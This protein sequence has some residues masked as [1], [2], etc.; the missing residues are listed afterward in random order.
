MKFAQ[1]SKFAFNVKS[2]TL[3]P[4]KTSEPELT[5]IAGIKG[6]FKINEAASK[7]MGLK[8][9]DYLAF[10]SNE[11]QI[12]LIKEA[13][14]DTNHESHEDA[15]EFV[16]EVGGVENLSI[17]WGIAKGWPLLDA[18][19]NPLTTKK[20]LTK[21]EE[22]KLRE[23]GQVDEDGKVIA[24][25]IA[26]MKGSRLASKMKELKTGMILEGTD[27]TNC[28]LLRKVV[29]EDKHAVYSMNPSPV[30]VTFPN[31]SGSVDVDVFL[32]TFDREDD[33]IE[34]GN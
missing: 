21:P 31:G 1:S 19:D 4:P 33:K 2:T 28:P 29:A 16:N 6:K 18:N 9:Y 34:R 11:D 17:Q 30:K 20:P 8:P 32:I 13:F 14:A 22:K 7:A 3:R 5:A 24:P 23:A 26:A 27:S 25:E 12:D 10:V 15:V